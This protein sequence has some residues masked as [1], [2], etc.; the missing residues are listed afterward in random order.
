MYN[1]LQKRGKNWANLGALGPG[2]LDHVEQEGAG[3]G[4]SQGQNGASI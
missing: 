3:G 4:D 2:M 1:L